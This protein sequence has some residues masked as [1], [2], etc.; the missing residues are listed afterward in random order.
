MTSTT[1]Q[2]LFDNPSLDRNMSNVL[3]RLK[4]RMPE[5]NF[6]IFYLIVLVMFPE[7]ASYIS[8]SSATPIFASNNEMHQ[9]FL[10]LILLLLP[11]LDTSQSAFL[12]ST[13]QLAVDIALNSINQ[14]RFWNILVDELVDTKHFISRRNK[15]RKLTYTKRWR[16]VECTLND[17]QF[18]TAFR[19]SRSDFRGLCRVLFRD[20]KVFP[21]DHKRVP[22][23][24][25]IQDEIKVAAV[26]AYLAGDRS[27]TLAAGFFHFDKTSFIHIM[28]QVHEAALNALSYPNFFD[29]P[30]ELKKLAK[31]FQERDKHKPYMGRAFSDIVGALDGYAIEITYPGSQVENPE[32]YKNHKGFYAIILQAICDSRGR[33]IYYDIQFAG[34]THDSVGWGET[35]LADL[36]E[37]G[38]AL[39]GENGKEYFIV[40]SYFHSV[41]F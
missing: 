1:G 25:R 18:Q 5:F 6:E 13:E 34:K 35:E 23:S 20:G 4:T 37:S 26:L 11:Y 7:V 19:M 29:D 24:Q 39:V 12:N 10:C 36:I 3:S 38:R 32:A 21:T 16:D 17:V 27:S 22:I 33:I 31:G 40:V 9:K 28:A 2:F 8:S 30:I 41:L 14:E 15:R